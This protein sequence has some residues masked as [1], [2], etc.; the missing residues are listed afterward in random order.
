VPAPA[1]ICY[2]GRPK[3]RS[4]IQLATLACLQVLGLTVPDLMIV[5]A[6]EVIE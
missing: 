1:N 2:P 6:D 5:R 3:R 4:R